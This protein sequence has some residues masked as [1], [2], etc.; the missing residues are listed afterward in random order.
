MSHIGHPLLGDGKYG[1]NKD[2]RAK[3]YKYQA[4]YSYRLRFS[5]NKDT[6]TVLDYLDG[7]EFKI[8]KNDIYFT[9]EYFK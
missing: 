1:I 6:E 7:K 5:F 4:L 9:A 2:D 8:S 3:G